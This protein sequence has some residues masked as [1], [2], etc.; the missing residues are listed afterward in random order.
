M[1]ELTLRISDSHKSFDYKG[2]HLVIDYPISTERLEKIKLA[3]NHQLDF[4]ISS[5]Q[6]NRSS[7]DH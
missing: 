3:I 1:A 6:K 7:H 5:S 4:E 2:V